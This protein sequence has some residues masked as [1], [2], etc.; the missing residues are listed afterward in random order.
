MSEGC[1]RRVSLHA[2]RTANGNRWQTPTE[3]Y[4]TESSEHRGEYP[5]K[6]E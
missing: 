4:D 3:S 1:V 5:R 2:N 6:E